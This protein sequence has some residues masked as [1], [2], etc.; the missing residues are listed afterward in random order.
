[1]S[2]KKTK[3]SNTQRKTKISLTMAAFNNLFFFCFNQHPRMLC[4]I[5]VVHLEKP[6][7]NQEPK[8][9]NNPTWLVL[10][11]CR[12]KSRSN[13]LL[14]YIQPKY[15]THDCCD[16]PPLSLSEVWSPFWID[17]HACLLLLH[18][19]FHFVPQTINYMT[20]LNWESAGIMELLWLC[21]MQ[22]QNWVV[23]QTVISILLLWFS[24][25]WLT[26]ISNLVYNLGFFKCNNPLYN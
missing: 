5:S 12:V 10:T 24:V 1:M 9:D 18:L 13:F 2:Q 8:R 14:I 6:M 20:T 25:T 7:N 26:S 21:S 17:L 19:A 16:F 22:L 15:L 11:L 23:N 3:Q 4:P